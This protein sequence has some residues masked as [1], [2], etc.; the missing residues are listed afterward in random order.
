MKKITQKN[1]RF[2]EKTIK[3]LNEITEK[4][5][6]TETKAIEKA[7]EKYLDA[8]NEKFFNEKYIKIKL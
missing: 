6:Y 3:I 7:L 1:F 5:D 2:S 4:M 8:I